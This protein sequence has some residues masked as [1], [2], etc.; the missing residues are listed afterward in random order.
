M[1]VQRWDDERRGPLSEEAV[2]EL[3]RPADDYRISRQ[4][5]E[6]GTAFPGRMRTGRV[7]VLSGRCAYSFGSASVQIAAGEFCDLVAGDFNFHVVG[8]GPCSLV[9]VWDLSG[10]FRFVEGKLPH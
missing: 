9:L 10:F 3:H 2:R 8:D 4:T 6:Q 7:Y 1:D 5:Y